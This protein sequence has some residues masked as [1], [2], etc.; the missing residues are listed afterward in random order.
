MTIYSIEPERRTLHGHFSCELEPVLTISSGDTVR[1]RTLDASWSVEP[2][3][4]PGGKSRKFTPRGRGDNGHALCGPVAI[5]GAEPGMVL[6]VYV[7]EVRPGS[8]GWSKAGGGTSELYK[9]LGV[10]KGEEHS[11]LW[12]LDTDTMTG[13]DQ[14]GR[15]IS[16]RPFLGIIGMPPPE[17]GM[18]S[19]G[20]PRIWGGN[21]D[22]KE[23]VQGSTLYLP[24]P[25]SGALVSVGDG[26]AVQGDGEVSGVGL[27]CPMD[28][29]ELTFCLHEDMGIL[30]PR[31][32]TPIG[33]LTFGFHEDLDEAAMI[34][35]DAMLELMNERHGLHRRDALAL[36][37][38]VVD[39]RVTQVVNR[40]L[41]VHAVLPHKFLLT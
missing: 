32:K 3:P 35:I 37:S 21:I 20:M 8:W 13:R 41:G 5:R 25:V 36:A 18:H 11:L 29:V 19:T 6:E 33:W 31:A 39:L 28:K 9:R 1:F 7:S 34:A 4:I 10:A 16:L 12:S 38:L 17:Q 2:P 22:C 15:V 14:Q 27:E 30:T 23:L 40:T 26:H 24:V